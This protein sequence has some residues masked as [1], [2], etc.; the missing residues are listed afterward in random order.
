M[1]AIAIADS[2]SYV[3]WGA[4]L[5]SRL[6]EGWDTELLIVRTAKLPSQGQLDTALR[7]TAVAASTVRVLG[8]EALVTHVASERPDV[9]IVATIGPLADIVTEAVLDASEHRPV[10]VSGMP[11]IAF[12][13]RRKALVFRSQ[14]DLLVMHSVTE[15][16]NFGELAMQNHLQH[17]FGLATLPFLEDGRRS[18]GGSDI[19]FAAQALVPRGREDRL[20]LLGWLVELAER[21]P[22]QRVVIKVRAT[23]AE[24]QTHAEVFAYD[25]LLAESYPQA[26][27]NLVVEGG[28][29]LDHLDR[30]AG[31]VTV[32]STAAIEAISL[33][34]PVLII[35]SFGVSARM[36]NQVFEGSGLLGGSAALL[37]SDFRLAEPAW[38]GENYF[39]GQAADTWVT[40]LTEL[41]GRN[42]AGD[43]PARPR[44]IRGPGGTLRRAWDRKRALGSA[45]RSLLGYLALA[46]G[47][48]ARSAILGLNELIALTTPTASSS[49]TPT[50]PLPLDD[51][52]ADLP[53]ARRPARRTP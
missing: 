29:M 52:A 32:S 17:A 38:L 3:K 41:V 30:A 36:I 39:H 13:A 7:G 6:P 9:V 48:P 53:R 27:A 45:D 43:L 5:L 46:I 22:Q 23:G 40:V 21:T 14:A 2:D 4:A 8:L 50:N 20:R 51:E 33:G 15:I 49:A 1:R 19:I 31:L 37:A 16:S 47:T 35:D 44:I 25:Q 34:V 18:S 42:A 11:G 10:I 24:A 12:P 26:P 28:P